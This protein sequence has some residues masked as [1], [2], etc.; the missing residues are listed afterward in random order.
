MPVIGDEVLDDS[1][2]TGAYKKVKRNEEQAQRKERP[3]EDTV[4]RQPFARQERGIIRN[5]SR[6]HCDLGLSCS[7]IVRK[8]IFVVQV[9]FSGGIE[10]LISILL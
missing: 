6:C 1:S 3:S 9:T 10:G 5:Q 2:R 4:R 7:R 8:L